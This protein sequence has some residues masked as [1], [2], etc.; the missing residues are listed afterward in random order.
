[1]QR[2]ARFPHIDALRAIA[3]LA[4]LGTHAAIFAGAD[5]PGSLVGHCAQ[6]LEVGV[7]IFFVISGFLL[8]RPFAAARAAGR[9]LPATGAYGWRR[10]LRIVPAYWVALTVSALA[11][12]TGGVLTASGA[13][14]Y[15]FGQTYREAT[16]S[17]GLTQAWTLCIEVAFYAFLPLWAWLLRRRGGRGA[18]T[19][20]WALGALAVASLGW[21]V[22][23]LAGMDPHQIE[24]TPL[25]IAMPAY[26]D[27]FALGMG[28]AVLSVWLDGRPR[29]P[30]LVALLDRRPALAWAVAL[31]AF[32]VVSTGIGIGNRLFEPMTPAQYLG[33]HLLYAVIGVTMVVPAVVGTP[34]RG[35]VRRLLANPVLGW[36]GVVSYGLYLWHLTAFSLLSRWGFGSV[37]P[38][39][40]YLAWPLA[41]LALTSLVAG[42]SWYGV[43]RPL[44]R[45]KGLVP[46]G[47]GAR[48]PVPPA[49][50]TVPLADDRAAP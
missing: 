41:G 29:P 39:H 27:Q 9:S 14:F 10:V 6:R 32:V 18:A 31:A 5:R 30:R 34:G 26:L 12:G 2:S 42:A 15:L 36:L 28:L 7:A 11:L 45:L 48:R 4:V 37:A 8:Y 38:I 25:L 35:L 33:R 24:V 3:A 50:A 16:I 22:V 21:K 23:L 17:G 40:P 49:R 19:E 1:M 46:A 20:A 47:P 43:E 44:L 13:W